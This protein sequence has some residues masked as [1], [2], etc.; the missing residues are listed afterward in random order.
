MTDSFIVCVC[1]VWWTTGCVE[2]TKGLSSSVTLFGDFDLFDGNYSFSSLFWVSLYSLVCGMHW[3]WFGEASLDWSF[4][5]KLTPLLN[6]GVR[7]LLHFSEISNISPHRRHG[8]GQ[9]LFQTFII[10]AWMIF[11]CG[12]RLWIVAKD[13]HWIEACAQIVVN[14]SFL[15]W[16]STYSA[17]E[18]SS[19][20]S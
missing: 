5:T 20:P 16:N 17:W 6:G 1:C 7:V 4:S 14:W 13:Q 8:I 2:D 18:S 11:F 10:G 12:C 9:N 3:F 19:L 15:A